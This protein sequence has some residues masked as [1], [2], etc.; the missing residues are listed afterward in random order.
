[1]GMIGQLRAPCVEDGCE[2]D[3]GAE[4]LRVGGNRQHRIGR[5][6]EQQV[7]DE[8]L[9]VEGDRGDLGRQREHDV[10]IA[11]REEVGLA[12]LEPGACSSAL[13]PRAMPVAATVVGDPPMPAVGAGFDMARSEEHTS[14]LQSLMRSSY[15]VFCLKKKKK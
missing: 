4:V 8:R 14:E 11:D 5:R 10:E 6:L 3:P 1:M 2:A 15:A 13:A 7:I 9:V 12:G